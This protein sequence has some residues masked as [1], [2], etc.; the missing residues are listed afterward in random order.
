MK[1]TRCNTQLRWQ[2]SRPRN[3]I[4]IQLL[5]SAGRKTRDLSLIIIS[6]SESRNSR[7]RLRFVF[8]EKTSRSCTMAMLNVNYQRMHN[9]PHFDYIL[10]SKLPQIFHFTNSRHVQA[11]FK[12]S[13]FDFLDSNLSTRRNLSSYIHHIGLSRQVYKQTDEPRYTTA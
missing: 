9:S 12:L 11:I 8:E 4:A 10:V 13:H 1:L 3:V 6:R 2:N 5:I 7:T